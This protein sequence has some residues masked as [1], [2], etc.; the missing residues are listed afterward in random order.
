[1]KKVLLIF[2]V[3]LILSSC[4]TDNDKIKNIPQNSNSNQSIPWI[5]E[6]DNR[7]M[8]DAFAKKDY[9]I[10][11]KIWDSNFKEQCKSSIIKENAQDTKNENLCDKLKWNQKN[12]CKDPIILVKAKEKKDISLCAK[13][14][15][16]EKETCRSEIIS[17]M[18]LNSWDSA[19]C[20]LISNGTQKNLCLNEVSFQKAKK[21]WDKSVCDR[22]DFM[23]KWE[24]ILDAI[25]AKSVSDWNMDFCNG[26]DPMNKWKCQQDSIVAIS[27]K[28]ND[29]SLCKS[30]SWKIF[31][32]EDSCKMQV[33]LKITETDPQEKYCYSLS[34]M[35]QW[36][37]FIKVWTRN[38]I[39]KWDES[40]CNI[41]VDH[42]SQMQCK[43]LYNKI[44]ADLTF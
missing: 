21:T 7:I 32:S 31:M 13:I 25:T 5:S 20:D 23:A 6:E 30:Y 1:M 41:L 43:L 16:P 26:L 27:A 22:L 15:G 36:N 9:I 8:G 17:Y 3:C 40:G 42:S 35:S 2:S 4:G 34:N 10:C 44:S 28:K 11:E 38:A 14:S 18:A 19:N 37:C 39:L 24:C 12:F 29:F 33:I